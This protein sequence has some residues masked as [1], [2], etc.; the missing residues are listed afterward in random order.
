M[1]SRKPTHLIVA[2][3][4]ALG[5][6][7][8]AV[9]CSNNT[10]AP[11]PTPTPTLTV[12]SVTIGP[13]SIAPGGTAQGTVTL[14]ATTGATVTLTSSNTGVAT[15]PGSVAVAA[16]QTSATFTVTG[17]AAGS[18]TITAAVSGSQGSA[19]ITV[20]PGAA[21]VLGLTLSA[22]S[23]VG[24][25]PVT[26]TL[27]I[28]SPAPAG[29]MVVTLSSSDPVTVPAS[30]TIPA[31]QTTATFTVNTRAVGGAFNNVPI[32]ASAG[33]LNAAATLT[34]TPAAP[35]VPVARF[36]VSG[37]SGT[38]TCRVTNGGNGFDCTFNGSTSTGSTGATVNQ[39]NWSY[40][41]AG[42][43]SETT[44]VPTLTPSPGCGVIGDGP[45][46]SGTTSLLMK[47]TLTV[48]DT[49]GATSAVA[50]NNGVRVL[51][52]AGSCNF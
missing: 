28:S 37:P 17:V 44:T 14:S 31:G 34:V 41:I 36:G 51:P 20:A 11:A 39:W 13:A 40:S 38:D 5:S 3:I 26:G 6:M 9:Q 1:F 24:G 10:P 29:G 7:L 22:S 21:Q 32:N 8:A 47:V 16:G 46:P 35:P 50:S 49:T 4:A 45:L 2:S 52:Q 43:K 42:S 27:V 15:V 18:S 19:S 12:A 30:V 25:N 48:R 23:V 33:S